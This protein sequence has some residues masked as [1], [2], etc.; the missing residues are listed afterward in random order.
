M[1]RKSKMSDLASEAMVLPKSELYKVREKKA[2]LSIGIP[3][4][5]TNEETRVPLSPAAVRYLSDLGYSILVQSEAGKAAGF[6]NNEY[7][8]NGARIVYEKKPIFEAG[9][10]LKIATPSLE[11][12]AMM[13][14][15]QVLISSFDAYSV[16]KEQ[17][18]NM[19]KKR[20]VALCYNQLRDESG[21]LPVVHSMSE[22]AGR[23]S[24]LIAVNHFMHAKDQGIL[25]GGITG[26]PPSEVLILGAGTVGQYAA[27]TALGLGANVRVFDTSLYRLRR[28]KAIGLH[29]VYNSIIQ[30]EI[31]S[32]AL[33][34]S[35]LVIGALRAEDGRTP[36]VV[37]EDM[38]MQMK[39]GALMIDVSIDQGGCFATSGLTTH[40]NP[41]FS[42]H[43]V[44][45]YCVPNIPSIVPQTASLALS[46]ILTHFLSALL[47]YGSLDNYMWDKVFIRESVYLYKGVLTNPF[48]GQ[49]YN[50]DSKSIDILLTSNL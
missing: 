22:I 12:I 3:A 21:I 45:H 27:R 5:S 8:E 32:Q 6:S 43:G 13:K 15:N 20:I 47:D 33:K 37:S 16:Q 35:N 46:N 18:Y 38:V 4:E 30:P 42:K 25:T 44:V 39:E 50:I 11:E 29:N 28:L 9:I 2:Q 17:V 41:I 1:I 14:G 7:S 49:T 31:L 23:A 10:I 34:N 36:C 19:L 48:I 24:V 26:M 40:S